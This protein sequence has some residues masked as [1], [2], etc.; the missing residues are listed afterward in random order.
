M[1]LQNYRIARQWLRELPS[2]PI[3]EQP[4]GVV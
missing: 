3:I 1:I 2:H 4:V